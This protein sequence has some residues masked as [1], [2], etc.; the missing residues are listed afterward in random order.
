[1]ALVALTAPLA[2]CGWQPLYGVTKD[3]GAAG[4]AA[5]QMSQI[6]INPIA[7]R[8]GQQLYNTLRDRMN[9]QG[10]PQNPTYDLIV[11]LRQS[12]AQSLINPDQTAARIDLTF[13]ADYNLYRRDAPGVSVFHGQS[14][15]TTSYD[16]LNDPYASVVSA[17]DAKRRGAQSLAD[18]IANRLATYLSQPQVAAPQPAPASP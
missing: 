16:L 14:R 17:D 10:V 1:M 9:P 18:D 4:S 8:V 7:D 3:T 15:N 13:Y 6:H 5:Q 12:G 2:G 11:T